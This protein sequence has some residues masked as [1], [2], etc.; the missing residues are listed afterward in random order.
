LLGSVGHDGSTS[1]CGIIRGGVGA[2]ADAATTWP[3]SATA[4]ASAITTER[5]FA[6]IGVS[7]VSQ[8]DFMSS[9]ASDAITTA[10]GFMRGDLSWGQN[11]LVG[12]QG[13]WAWR[14]ACKEPASR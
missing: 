14:A 8:I 4:A 7:S 10:R 6:G 3:E 2:C 11:Y 9:I 5:V 1:K 13:Q 12:Q